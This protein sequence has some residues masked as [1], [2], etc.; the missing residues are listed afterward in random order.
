MARSRRVGE[1]EQDEQHGME[2][3]QRVPFKRQ[4]LRF[5]AAVYCELVRRAAILLRQKKN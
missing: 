3:S 1:I 2:P 4:A 5:F